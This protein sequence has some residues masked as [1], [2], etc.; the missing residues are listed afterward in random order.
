M[1]PSQRRLTALATI[2]ALGIVPL[3]ASGLTSGELPADQ[4]AS[5]SAPAPEATSATPPPETA[6]EPAPVTVAAPVETSPP[7]PAQDPSVPAVT[8]PPA[9]APTETTTASP[10]SVAPQPATSAGAGVT[11]TSPTTAPPDPAAA[12]PSAAEVDPAPGVPGPVYELTVEDDGLAPGGPVVRRMRMPVLGPITY[13]DDF[14]AC[15]DGCARKHAGNDLIGARLQP[16]VAAADGVIDHLVDDHPTAGWGVVIE[17]AEGWQYRYFHLNN[18]TPGTDDGGDD[19]TWRFAPGVVAGA[20]VTAG[21]VIGWMGDSGNS[22]HS[23]PHLHFELRQPDGRAVNPYP[24][25]RWAQ[26]VQHCQSPN[27]PFA[28]VI[29][30]L[31]EPA[32]EIELAVHGGALLLDRLGLAYPRA[33]AWVVGDGRYDDADGACP[34]PGAPIDPPIAPAVVPTPSGG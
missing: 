27:G 33:R 17:D 18:D 29:V 14:A 26:R 23:V 15:R 10:T 19:G 32:H 9:S 30:P 31:P 21:Q 7:A 11:T 6:A 3:Q 20:V 24:S 1:T 5:A 13:A 12:P 25:L 16:V 8:D 28:G 4:V 2:G 34:E 22:E